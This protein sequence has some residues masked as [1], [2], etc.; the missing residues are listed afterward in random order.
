[1]APKTR[2]EIQRDH[3]ERKKQEGGVPKKP[4]KP[5]GEIQRDYRERK[6]LED[7]KTYLQRERDRKR[8]AYIPTSLLTESEIA[9]RRKLNRE[10]AKRLRER[11]AQSKLPQTSTRD[12]NQPQKMIVKLDFK[13]TKTAST[14][15]RK[16]I[17]RGVAK[18]HKEIKSLQ[19]KNV[20]LQRKAWSL[21]KQ[22]Q[23]NSKMTKKPKPTTQEKSSKNTTKQ[24]KLNTEEG[25]NEP[26]NSATHYSK[27]TGFRSSRFGRGQAGY[28]ERTTKKQHA[29]RSYS[30]CCIWCGNPEEI[31]LSSPSK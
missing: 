2:A 23:R 13:A 9:K 6:K 11:R 7:N 5:R 1:M 24:S 15:R 30:Q 18:A 3:R 14:A 16:R 19:E 28:A 26:A 8:K 22:L 25:R 4:R 21:T 12:A 20:Q 29:A 17:S 27:A 10:K 31:P